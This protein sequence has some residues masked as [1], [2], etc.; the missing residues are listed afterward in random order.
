MKFATFG[1]DEAGFSGGF[2]QGLLEFGRY[3]IDGVVD[4]GKFTMAGAFGAASEIAGGQPGDIFQ[5][6]ADRPAE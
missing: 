4:F 2:R 3:F 5:N 6:M 1:S